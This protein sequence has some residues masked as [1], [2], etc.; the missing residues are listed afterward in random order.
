MAVTQEV[1]VDVNKAITSLRALEKKFKDVDK[2]GIKPA[3]KGLSTFVKAGIAG[4]AALAAYRF[5]GAIVDQFKQMVTAGTEFQKTV[6][7]IET[8]MPQAE[9]NTKR[10]T[11]SLIDL[12]NAYGQDVQAQARGFYDV[13]SAGVQ[14]FN[15]QL[16]VLNVTNKVAIGGVT[17]TATATNLLVTTMNAFESQ[18]AT[19]ES[20]A[21]VLFTTVKQG[22]T[23][24][25]QLAS[26]LGNVNAIASTSGVELKEVGASMAVLTKN[27]LGTA[28][29]STALR[30]A[31]VSFSKPTKEAQGIIK[32]LGIDFSTTAIKQ[33][34]FYN[35]LKQVREATN[36]NIATLQ[37]LFPNVRAQA[38]LLPI[39]TTRW[40]EFER[41]M[42]NF[43]ETSGAT[44]Q[45][46]KRVTDTGAFQLK[47]F[48]T[49]FRN[50]YVQVSSVIDLDIADFF[51]K[52]GKSIV[53]NEKFVKG[54]ARAFGLFT[55]IVTNLTSVFLDF[56]N[57]FIKFFKFFA[58]VAARFSNVK[59]FKDMHEGLEGFSDA[60]SGISSAISE[61]GGDAFTSLNKFS[62]NYKKALEKLEKDVKKIDLTPKTAATDGED[63]GDKTKKEADKVVDAGFK[64]RTA[65]DLFAKSSKKQ[66]VAIEDLAAQ[67]LNAA[68]QLFGENKA[69]LIA[70]AIA[71]TYAGATRALAT[72]NP[73]ASFIA[74]ATIVATGLANVAKIRQ[75]DS[76]GYQKGGI[77]PGN[78]FEG[79]RVVARVNSGEMILNRS[80]QSNLFKMI[81]GGG[82]RQSTN[83]TV[84]IQSLTG[85]IPRRSLDNMIDQIRQRVEFGNKRFV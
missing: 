26:S 74:A 59:I 25:G 50:L 51:K 18:G 8:L 64:F 53:E 11:A 57:L 40:D 75:Q 84:N 30:S 62:D 85:D 6:A 16:E 55:V 47:K 21:D 7:E 9:R 17:D 28:E 24:I 65:G 60:L 73:P 22:V 32:R 63:A 10:L 5:A 76:K 35:V 48:E 56:F 70:E 23:T 43:N 20:V 39:L 1:I 71:N 31:I 4:L 33:K 3:R 27:G 45:A 69:L 77:I 66:N 15:K 52:L 46:F 72:I 49:G 13:V 80:Q 41:Q 54:M 67:G 58:G 36:G 81:E 12:S 61:F 19:A 34:G 82:G 14:G 29:A 83:V 78:Q 38:A 37:K 79:D 2:K 68:T 44:D 42:V